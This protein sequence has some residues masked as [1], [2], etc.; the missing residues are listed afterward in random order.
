MNMD[1]VEK[2][3]NES[4]VTKYYVFEDDNSDVESQYLLQ[5]ITD[6]SEDEVADHMKN[7]FYGTF[8]EFEDEEGVIELEEISVDFRY[9]IVTYEGDKQLYVN[10]IGFRTFEHVR[11][12]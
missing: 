2:Q 10:S 6:M 3:L 8:V 9:G 11:H 7:A 12:S 4:P 1:L 5:D